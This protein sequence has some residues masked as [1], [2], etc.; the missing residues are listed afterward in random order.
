VIKMDIE[1]MIV[2]TLSDIVYYFLKKGGHIVSSEIIS[3]ENDFHLLIE[4][5]IDVNEDIKKDIAL[6]KKIKDH[7]ELK[8]Y[9]ALGE[10]IGNLQGIYLIAPY[11][12]KIDTEIT[13]GELKIELFVKKVK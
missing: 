5:N 12:S 10:N 9:S 3:L 6:M 8:Y 7:P 4:V 1:K 2:I 11:L 13:D